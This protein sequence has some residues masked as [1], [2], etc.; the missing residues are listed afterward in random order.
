MNDK[1][2]ESASA[3]ELVKK[4]GLDGEGIYKTIKANL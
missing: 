2:G 1:F 3:G 4:Y